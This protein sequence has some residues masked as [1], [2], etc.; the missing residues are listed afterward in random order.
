MPNCSFF[1]FFFFLFFFF[2]FFFYVFAIKTE[3][4]HEKT[5][6]AVYVNNKG[7]DQPAHPGNKLS[8]ITWYAI[9]TLWP[10]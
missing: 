5:C 2:F 3:P 8:V 4:R 6:F 1:F 10:K 7:A 9:F